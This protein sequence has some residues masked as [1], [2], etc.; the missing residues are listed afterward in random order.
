MSGEIPG[1]DSEGCHGGQT[2]G[3]SDSEGCHGGS[4]RWDSRATLR[5]V[6]GKGLVFL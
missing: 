1:G 3:I 4:D 5:G 2:N 6:M